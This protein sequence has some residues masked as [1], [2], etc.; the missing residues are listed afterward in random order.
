MNQETRNAIMEDF[1]ILG[2]VT[3]KSGDYMGMVDQTSSKILV[4]EGTN[5]TI[6]TGVEKGEILPE[7]RSVEIWHRMDDGTKEV[8]SRDGSGNLSYLLLDRHGRYKQYASETLE[9]RGKGI[10]GQATT[11]FET[12]QTAVKAVLPYQ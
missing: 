10:N 4:P 12:T 11:I 8:V 2:V 6:W 9:A 7:Q 3:R 5:M 1:N